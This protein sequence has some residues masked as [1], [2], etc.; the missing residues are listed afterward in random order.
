MLPCPQTRINMLELLSDPQAWLAFLALTSLE[1]VLGIDNLV[2][3]AIVV[4]RLPKQQQPLARQLGL[5]LALGT[6]LALLFALSW[7]IGLT[8]PWFSVQGHEISGR[9]LILIVGGLF[10]LWKA[11]IE[12]HHQM[13]PQDED[14]LH[15]GHTTSGFTGT[16]IQ[17]A[18]IDMVFSL[19]SVITA[20]GMAKHIEVM[21]A[22]VIVAMGVMMLSAKSIGEFIAR[23][24]TFKVLALSFLVLIG[25]MLVAEGFAVHVPK[26]YIYFAMAYAISVELINMRIRRRVKKPAA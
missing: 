19:D 22:A 16:I 21:I 8:Q 4:G 13:H 7:L 5:G 12:M 26:G 18:L 1:I 15:A 23:H 25:A 6:R 3:L 10:L 14:L 20:L 11:T 9:D 17:I 24:P 2:F